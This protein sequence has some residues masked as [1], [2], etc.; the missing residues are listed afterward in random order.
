MELILKLTFKHKS[1]FMKNAS[2]SVR[3]IR[4]ILL[5]MLSQQVDKLWSQPLQVQLMHG[6]PAKK[7]TNNVEDNKMIYFYVTLHK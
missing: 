3:E 1:R 5:L 2:F 4:R 7:R 6:L